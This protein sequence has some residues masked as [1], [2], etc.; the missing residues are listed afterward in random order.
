M[1][2]YFNRLSQGAI[3]HILSGREIKDPVLQMLAYKNMPADNTKRFRL[4][5]SDGAYSYQCCI[6]MG[7]QAAKVE[8][9]EIDRYC[10][11]KVSRLMLNEIQGRQVIVL[12]DPTVLFTGVQVGE[13]LGNPIPFGSPDAPPLSNFNPGASLQPDN[14]MDCE[15]DN[16]PFDEPNNRMNMS[17]SKKMKNNQGQSS[18]RSNTNGGGGN[19]LNAQL[20]CPISSITPYSNKWLIKGRVTT[21][22]NKRSWNNAKGE[23]VLFSFEI[24]DESGDI[25]LTAF[26]NDCERLFDYIEV[27]KI[28]LVST[29]VVKQANKQYSNTTSD[30]EISANSDTI[31]ELC[32]DESG[33]PK[34]TYDF[35]TFDQLTNYLNNFVDI[36]G[37]VKRIEE[38]QMIVAKKTNKEMT[39][40]DLIIID[41]T[42]SEVLLTVWNEMAINFPGQEEDVIV[43]RNCRV[44]EF[45]NVSLSTGM[46]STVEINPDTEKVLE[47]KGWYARVKNDLQTTNLTIAKSGFQADWKNL[48]EITK[49]NVTQSDQFILQTKATIFQM[50]K[51]NLYK[52]CECNKKL[53]DLNNGFYRCEKCSKEATSF[54]WRMI[55]SFGIADHTKSVWVQAFHDDALKIL[56]NIDIVE[57]GQLYEN[58]QTQLDEILRTVTFSSYIFKLRAKMEHF[59]DDTRIRTSVLGIA[60]VDFKKYGDYLLQKIG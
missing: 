3:G 31:V 44:S 56:P 12:A 2:N 38:A 42:A 55:L 49:D 47:L 40:R 51:A 8:S 54:N 29:G 24:K 22:S 18:A 11:L 26:K 14:S 25:R 5:L 41:Q 9:G 58:N 52:A 57:L 53:V 1:T 35:K 23:G 45:N 21:K 59:N 50:G 16:D 15:F 36:I 30:Y 33:C 7:D 17:A 13:K 20:A 4:V 34:I 19:R 28:Y 46:T 6:I 10:L 37:I 48:S 39:K 43:V 60:P 32:N 27:G